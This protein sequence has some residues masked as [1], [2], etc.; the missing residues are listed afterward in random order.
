MPA[1]PGQQRKAA[2]PARANGRRVEKVEATRQSLFDAALKVVG[3]SGYAGSSIAKIAARANVAQ[4]TFYSYFMSQQDVFDQ[5]L[6]YLGNRLLNEIREKLKGCKDPYE[7]EAIGFQAYFD[8]LSENPEFER[9]LSEAAVFTPHGFKAHVKN[10]VD[11]YM[12]AFRHRS[13][14]A[15]LPHY[16]E[17]ELEAVTY[18]LLGARAYLSQRFMAGGNGARKLPSWAFTAY[19]KFLRYGL[20]GPRRTRAAGPDVSPTEVADHAGADEIE[21]VSNNGS[22]A[23]L[24]LEFDPSRTDLPTAVSK[25]SLAAG[26]ALIGNKADS[27]GMSNFSLSILEAPLGRV[28][29]RATARMEGREGG[30]RSISVST[31]AATGETVIASASIL[32]EPR[33]AAG[34]QD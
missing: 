33:E 32:M 18:I 29:L 30:A 17:R 15:V 10:I 2:K 34:K 8:F 19:M 4:G 27:L 21:V 26:L 23:T 6:P 16:S 5:L 13:S 11:G 28:T 14:R 3:E 24:E 9:I 1:K 7:R 20:T 12:R 25:L 31:R 22:S